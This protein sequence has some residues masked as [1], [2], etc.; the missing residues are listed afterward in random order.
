MA[1]DLP[2]GDIFKEGVAATKPSPAPAFNMP[3]RPASAP[4]SKPKTT[5]ERSPT[6]AA[7][8]NKAGAPVF[9]ISHGRVSRGQRIGIYGPGGVG[10]TSLA[11]LLGKGSIKPV[12]IDL[13]EGSHELDVARVSGIE[14]W[15]YLTDALAQTSLW[16]DYGAIVI[17]SIT[18]AEGMALA[19]TIET[20]PHEKAGNTI[21]RIEDY[22]YGKGYQHAFEVFKDLFDF[23]DIHADAGR[24]I[25]L[26]AHECATNVP[27][28][29]GED[30]LQYQPRLQSMSS[31]KAST[32]HH[33]KEWLDHLFFIG[34]DVV[35]KD[36]KGAGSGT[37]TIY[38]QE[39]PTHWAKSRKLRD[40]IEYKDG[41][42][43]L[44][45]ALFA[46]QG[47]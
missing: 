17:D 1:K 45:K 42:L 43:E 2:I 31:G 41:G 30:F 4:V 47:S 6:M 37:R 46:K 35:S 27:N 29:A 10:K 11:A 34:Y 21:R 40:P 18:R 8:S 22:G 5:S 25:I 20:V 15:A 24:H 28:P 23:L 7:S 14:T 32:R 12:F 26:I 3:P 39:R 16:S 13:D 38:P 19:H 9:S 36:G 33:V 44:W